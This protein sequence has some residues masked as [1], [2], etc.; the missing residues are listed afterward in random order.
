MKKTNLKN[1]IS[2]IDHFD[3]K[4]TALESAINIRL[5]ANETSTDLKVTAVEKAAELKSKVVEV[6]TTLA[7]QNLEKRLDH[8]NE[9]REALSDQATTFI[10][11]SEYNIHNDIIINDVR[12]LRESKSQLEGKASQSSVNIAY[13]LSI[14][15]IIVALIAIF[16]K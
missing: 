14:I 5:L 4:I 15:S 6:S 13:I 7:A 1:C 11:K 9:F 8:M 12:M 3:T 10:T 16:F 2:L